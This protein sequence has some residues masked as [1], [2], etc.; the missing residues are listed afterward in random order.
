ML[1]RQVDQYGKRYPVPEGISCV[2]AGLL[3]TGQCAVTHRPDE[4]QC[5]RLI[6]RKFV[7][8]APSTSSNSLAVIDRKGEEASAVN[9]VADYGKMKKAYLPLSS[10]LRRNC[11]RRSSK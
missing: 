8:S 10:Q 11:S 4:V 3:R 2:G 9:E 1:Y 6:W 5:T 7:R